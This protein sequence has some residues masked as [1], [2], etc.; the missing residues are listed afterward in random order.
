MCLRLQIPSDH[1]CIWLGRSPYL[2]PVSQRGHDTEEVFFTEYY[3]VPGTELRHQAY[4]P[5]FTD[6]ETDTV[7]LLS[8]PSCRSW[9]C[10]CLASLAPEITCEVFGLHT[11]PNTFPPPSLFIR[12]QNF[13]SCPTDTHTLC[14]PALCFRPLPP[15]SSP[16][17]FHSKV[18][19]L[20]DRPLN[21]SASST[22]IW[23]DINFGINP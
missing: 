8:L 14:R 15:P 13:Y 22:T 16:R 2:S 3:C 4:Y 21:Q 9:A 23:A 10:H 7:S 19:V 5:H 20:G 18:P 1:L 17:A 12:V 6:D 11:G